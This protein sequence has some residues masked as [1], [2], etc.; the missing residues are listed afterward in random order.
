MVRSR[1]FQQ[2]QRVLHHG[3]EQDC[4]SDEGEEGVSRQEANGEAG[5]GGTQEGEG[6]T[7]ESRTQESRTQEVR[8][9]V[10]TGKAWSVKLSSLQGRRPQ[11]FS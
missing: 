10:K 2:S 7:E 11:I 1:Q 4:G 8:T 5:E 9:Q 6:G 3:Y